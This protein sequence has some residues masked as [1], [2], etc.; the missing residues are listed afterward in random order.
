MQQIHIISLL[1]TVR[2]LIMDIIKMI[3][4]CLQNY[5]ARTKSHPFEVPRL[6]LLQEQVENVINQNIFPRIILNAGEMVLIRAPVDLEDYRPLFPTLINHY[7]SAIKTN[8]CWAIIPMDEQEP[9]VNPMLQDIETL[10]HRPENQPRISENLT[11]TPC[12]TEKRFRRHFCIDANKYTN[13]GF[14]MQPDPVSTA[15]RGDPVHLFPP[16]ES[17]YVTIEPETSYPRMQRAL[18]EEPP[19]SARYVNTFQPTRTTPPLF[20]DYF[21]PLTTGAE[22]TPDKSSKSLLRES[23]TK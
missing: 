13:P 15:Q 21:I 7:F 12:E 16:E 22:R 10:W 23:T 14:E 19:N 1:M 5:V 8:Q 18:S 2:A 20:T 9:W 17:S 3:E 4:I 11:S 6:T